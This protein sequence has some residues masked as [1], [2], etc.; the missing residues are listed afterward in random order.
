MLGIEFLISLVVSAVFVY[1]IRK[2]LAKN[3][4]VKEVNLQVR[5]KDIK[6]A[7]KKEKKEKEVKKCK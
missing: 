5:L 6:K 3:K 1:F 7:R 4:K 2:K